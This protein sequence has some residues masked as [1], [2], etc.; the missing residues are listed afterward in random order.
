M[1]NEKYTV[2]MSVYIKEKAEY[3]NLSIQS[4]L[5]QT[6][7]PSEFIIVKD[8]PLTGEL[9]AVINKFDSDNPGLFKII[10]IETNVGLGPALAMGLME[11]SFE[12]IARMD[13]DDF[14]V[15]ERC[16]KQLLKFE[17]NP[18]IE[19]VGSFEAEF[20]DDLDNIISI[21]RVP[22]THEEIKSFMKKRCAL[23]HP[24][25]MYKKSAVI[26]SGNYQPVWLYEDYDLFARMILEHDVKSFNLQ[27]PLYYI[28]TSEDFF[29]RRGGIHYLK[30]VLKFKWGQ[31]RK[32]H[33]SFADFCISG[34]GQAFVCLLPNSL[35][36]A[37]YI[38]ILR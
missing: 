27:E 8:G 15:K 16:E 26:K 1:R 24:T 22:E 25:V 36:K 12:L 2:L 6:V 34:M 31:L 28:R 37:F 13:S 23:L 9:E 7:P 10:S 14:S 30:T 35:R 4:M 11:S 3:L 38:K 19:I 20:I 29:K 5:K 32:G 21:H 18:D 33:M 17:M